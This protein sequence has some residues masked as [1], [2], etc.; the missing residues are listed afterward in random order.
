[1]TS[2]QLTI[3]TNLSQLPAVWTRGIVAATFE[4]ALAEFER[5]YGAAARCWQYQNNYYFEGVK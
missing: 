3:M 4:A 5:K 2:P 1:M